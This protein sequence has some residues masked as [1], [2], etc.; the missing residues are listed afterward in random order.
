MKIAIFQAHK[1]LFDEKIKDK[2]EQFWPQI[3]KPQCN[4]GDELQFFF[5]GNLLG[6]A[7]VSAILAPGKCEIDPKGTYI[8]SWKILWN[9]STYMAFKREQAQKV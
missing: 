4:P 3:Y 8:K 5:N 1:N 9:S 6:S 7:T 2:G